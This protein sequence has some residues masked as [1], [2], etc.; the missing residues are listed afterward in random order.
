MA[1]Q[2]LPPQGETASQFADR[3]G[4][5][6]QRQLAD[7]VAERSGEGEILFSMTYDNDAFA[8]ATSRAEDAAE[9]VAT[10]EAR[11]E[12]FAGADRALCRSALHE[13]GR[14]LCSDDGCRRLFDGAAS[15]GAE[16]NSTSGAAT[17]GRALAAVATAP[18]G[19]VEGT[20]RRRQLPAAAP[21]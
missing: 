1:A 17:L 8:A 21:E 15:A 3:L 10:A 9:R 12:V 14:M 7:A 19:V 18:E 4:A 2:F 16:R 11:C 13:T 6:D 5:A 20:L